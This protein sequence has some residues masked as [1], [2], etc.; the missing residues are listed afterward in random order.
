MIDL[1][2][3]TFEE[4]KRDIY[5]KYIT[6]FPK[7]ELRSIKSIKKTV[8][9]GIEKIYKI[10][11]EDKNVGFILLVKIDEKYPY[12]LDVLAIYK[13]YQNKGYGSKAMQVLLDKIVGNQGLIGE[14][15]KVCEDNPTSIKRF[16]FYKNLGFKK[17]ESEYLLY[18]VLYNPIVYGGL[19]NISK[20]EYDKIF[21]DH[22]Y[23][24]I[25]KNR[26]KKNCKIIK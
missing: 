19:E 16:D 6:L 20:E 18:N 23:I 5:D 13:E 21:F 14:I 11:C 3:I 4:F 8:K 7:D 1:V 25:G 24:N 17:I 2:E 15:E 9:M 26:S 22:Y 12:Y 10:I